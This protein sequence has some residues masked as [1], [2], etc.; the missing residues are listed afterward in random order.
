M[1]KFILANKN[2]VT[3]NWIG[4][5]QIFNSSIVV[6]SKT[7][8]KQEAILYKCVPDYWKSFPKPLRLV[9][10]WASVLTFGFSFFTIPL[11]FVFLIPQVWKSAPIFSSICLISV[12]ISMI[13]PLKEW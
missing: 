4:I 8:D 13:L 3:Y 11:C 6:M 5:H 12:I 1:R 10:G 7:K 2:S 9:L